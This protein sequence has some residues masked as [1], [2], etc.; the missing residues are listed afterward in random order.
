MDHR[1][2]SRIGL[3]V[4]LVLLGAGFLAVQFF[5]GLANWLQLTMSWPLIIVAVGAFI[6]V[7]GLLSGNPDAAIGACVVAGIGGILYYQNQSNDWG[8]WAYAWALI[9]GF[10]GIGMLFSGLLGGGKHRLGEGLWQI[11]ISA[12]LFAIF[13]SFLGGQRWLGPYWP[14]LLVLA[15]LIIIVRSFLRK[16]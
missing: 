13:S 7:V 5:P 16:H 12:I 14:L 1:M 3:G 2:R 9:P 6:L 11:L 10:N 15:G 8:S 4:L